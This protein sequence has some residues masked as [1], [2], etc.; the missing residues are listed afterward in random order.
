M[1]TYAL[2]FTSVAS[3]HSLSNQSFG[4][5][6]LVF[7]N[8]SSAVLSHLMDEAPVRE[9][10]EVTTSQEVVWRV[11]GTGDLIYFALVGPS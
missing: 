2:F 3:W 6:L 11:C 8:T 7:P 4:C 1:I 5:F 10:C 9:A